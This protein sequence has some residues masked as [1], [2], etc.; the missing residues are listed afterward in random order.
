M[1]EKKDNIG[2]FCALIIFIKYFMG[3]NDN[4]FYTNI[5]HI[6]NN[7]NL[8]RHTHTHLRNISFYKKKSMAI[9]MI[10]RVTLQF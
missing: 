4:S 7:F 9:L 10:S 2:T 1:C 8:L 3:K 6:I 5:L